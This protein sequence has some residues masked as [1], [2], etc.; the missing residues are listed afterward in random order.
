VT[1]TKRRRIRVLHLIVDFCEVAGGGL[2]ADFM[3]R[4]FEKMGSYASRHSWLLG[5]V[6]AAVI[7]AGLFL[8]RHNALV[9]EN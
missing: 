8:D 4:M 2:V 9:E 7:A 5:V 1:K 6:G 3:F